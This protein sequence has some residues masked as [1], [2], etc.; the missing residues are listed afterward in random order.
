MKINDL[1]YNGKK[2]SD[3]GFIIAKT[4]DSTFGLNR[5]E[6]VGD[7]NTVRN[8]PNHFGTKYANRLPLKYLITK[9]P[10]KNI[11]QNKQRINEDELREIQKWLTSPKTPKCLTVD[12]SEST[13]REYYGVFTEV[14]PYEYGDLYGIE[15]TFT[16][17]AP[18]GF[19]R[20]IKEFICNITEN[21]IIDNPTDELCEY[22]YPTI[23]IKPNQ[24]TS[25]SIQNQSDNNNIMMFNF[26]ELYSEIIIDCNHQR[27]IA[28]DKLLNLDEVG[29][30]I[31]E[32]SDYNN[33]NSGI[34][35]LY[36]L[37]FIPTNNSLTINGSGEFVIEY[38]TPVKA[39]GYY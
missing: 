28:D 5:D 2:L 34:F 8:T 33:I 24:C 22:I 15:I 38:K 18:Y 10:C 17:N 23:K 12:A 3:Y 25:F 19:N 37:R 32:I 29:W 16:C 9:N 26:K 4:I 11:S 21:L 7:M 30:D 35:N 14:E 39:G 20:N 1:C 31:Y 36:W 13:T 6:V 27:I